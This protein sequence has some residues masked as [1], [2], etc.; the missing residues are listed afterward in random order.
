MGLM[1]F[2]CN[3]AKKIRISWGGVDGMGNQSRLRGK[4]GTAISLPTRG[5]G[6]E[7]GKKRSDYL[8]SR[9]RG[10]ARASSREVLVGTWT[11]EGKEKKA[12]HN[13][14]STGM[15]LRSNDRSISLKNAIYSEKEYSA[16]STKGK[17]ASTVLRKNASAQ[18]KGDNCIYQLCWRGTSNEAEERWVRCLRKKQKE[19]ASESGE[20]VEA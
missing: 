10:E 2:S 20:R 1:G 13:Q 15:A 8:S 12:A 6:V 16:L 3:I 14:T 4:R 11:P 9:T 5:G 19:K 17:K 18:K 7:G